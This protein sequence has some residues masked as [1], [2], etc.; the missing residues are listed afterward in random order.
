MTMP[1][2]GSIAVTNRPDAA[3]PLAAPTSLIVITDNSSGCVIALHT[4]AEQAAGR[5]P[6]FMTESRDY[7][8]HMGVP[9]NA[10][11]APQIGQPWPPLP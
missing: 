6:A 11:P 2:P 4:D 8:A 5:V 7:T 1:I 3:A 9:L 10:A